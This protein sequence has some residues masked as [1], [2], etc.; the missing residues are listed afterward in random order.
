MRLGFDQATGGDE[1]FAQ[2]VLVRIIEP[3]S[4]AD[5]LRVLAEA[6]RPGP[7]YAI[8]ELSIVAQ[9]SA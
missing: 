1:V 2:L 8:R 7:S 3:A 6:G 4:K 9:E 5:S